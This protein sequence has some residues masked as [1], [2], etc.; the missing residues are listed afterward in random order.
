[1]EAYLD[2]EA[3]AFCFHLLGPQPPALIKPM[4]FIHDSKCH[5]FQLTFWGLVGITDGVGGAP[6]NNHRFSFEN[7]KAM[8]WRY[9][10][11]VGGPHKT[12]TALFIFFRKCKEGFPSKNLN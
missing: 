10:L 6:P 7:L 4:G 11:G 9:T 3:S 1:M 12:P 2:D 8:H 5:L